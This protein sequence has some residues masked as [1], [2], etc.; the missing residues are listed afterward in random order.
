MHFAYGE[1]NVNRVFR[2]SLIH[3]H[4]RR[5]R[6]Q[7]RK[8]IRRNRLAHLLGRRGGNMDICNLTTINKE[9]ISVKDIQELSGLS[10][11]TSVRIVAQVKEC[12]DTCGVRGVITRADWIFYLSR[13]Q[14]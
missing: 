14:A 6:V 1:K 3:I 9:F 11:D 12:S 2:T 13:N 10:Y 8:T 4:Q 7:V 5:R